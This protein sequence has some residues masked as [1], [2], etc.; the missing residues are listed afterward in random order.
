M[1]TS[2]VADSV[3]AEPAGRTADIIPFPMPARPAEPTPEDRLAVALA[4]LRSAMAEQ[5]VAVA[6]WQK[7]LV[8]LKATTTGLTDSLQRYRTNLRTLGT[9]VSNLQSKARALE[10][11]ANDVTEAA[12]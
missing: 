5:R 2:T 10:E 9:S 7:V 3:T 1:T 6:A 11:W 4:T 8:E 12:D